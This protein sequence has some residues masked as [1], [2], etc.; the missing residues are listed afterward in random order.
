MQYKDRSY[1]IFRI[2]KTMNNYNNNLILLT[3]VFKD[4]LL[5]FSLRY[6]VRKGLLCVTSWLSLKGVT[7]ALSDSM[8]Y[9]SWNLSLER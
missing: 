4:V 8:P 9:V 3:R 2:I 5:N 6:E 7:R 1:N